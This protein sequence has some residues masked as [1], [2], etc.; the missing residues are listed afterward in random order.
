MSESR[1]IIAANRLPVT[2]MVSDDGKVSYKRSPGGLVTALGALKDAY[3]QIW[4]GWPG[5]FDTS[6]A[7]QEKIA[8]DLKAEYNARPVF[9][10]RRQLNRYYYGFSNKVLWPT[11]HYLPTHIDYD[12]RDFQAY[13]EVNEIFAE[14]I[15]KVLEEGSDHDMIWVQ[16]YQLMLVPAMVRARFPEAKIGFFLHTPFPS[17]EVF[18]ALPY[19][20]ELLRGLLGSSLIGFHTFAYLR[21]FRS[22]ILHI[23]GI[24]SDM[25]WIELEDHYSKLGVFPISIDPSSIDQILESDSLAEARHVVRQVTR[26]RRMILSVDRLDYTKGIPERLK[27]YKKFLQ[28]NAHLVRDVVLV[29]ISVP[30][31]TEI[32]D[33]RHLKDQV[34]I[35]VQDILDTYEAEANPPIHYMYKG[36]PFERLVAFYEAADVALVT[37]YFDGMNLVAKEY[38]AAKKNEGVLILSEL[39]G[40]ASELGEALIINPWNMDQ[41]ASALEHALSMPRSEQ[42]RRMGA[43]YEKVTRNNVHYWANSFLND[44]SNLA[45]NYPTPAGSPIAITHRLMDELLGRFRQAKRPLVL[46]DYDGTITEIRRI[47]FDAKPDQELLELIKKFE[48]SGI[49][50]GI[51]SAR[52]RWDVE[53][54]LGEFQVSLS[55]EHGLWL[56]TGKNGE[57]EWKRMVDE[58]LELSW[59]QTV[60]EIFHQFNLKSPGSFT[61]EREASLAWHYRLSD[62][63]IGPKQARELTLHLSELLANQ[64]ADVV[65][66]KSV[67]EVISH[68]FQKGNIITEME[69]EGE[70]FDFILALGDDVTDEPIFSSLPESGISVRVGKGVSHASYRVGAVHDVRKLLSTI[71][72]AN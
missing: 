35:I 57:R 20:E 52:S 49:Q 3:E 7:D 39:A 10:T 22:S 32:P 63:T 61:E 2:V 59:Y 15:C 67:V 23:L 1:I 37:P 13:R 21:H 40:A 24:D 42:S 11:L 54:W 47:P 38:V 26:G 50:M 6:Q 8:A 60:R 4:I 14:Q 18:R 69:G 70:G 29:Q 43:M 51:L 44:L 16:D 71:V 28:N 56:S 12:E 45:T 9:L 19:R 25:E 27:A 68:G 53:D 36:V 48:T 55:A 17:S 62:P 30:S 33:Y 5:Q 65:N 41:I 34:E 66:G 31:R 46:T 58:S 72:E 64:S